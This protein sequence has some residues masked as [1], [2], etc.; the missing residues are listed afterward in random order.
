MTARCEINLFSF[1]IPEQKRNR[2]PPKITG[3]KAVIGLDSR[4]K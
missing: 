4:F 3:I 1:L 2:T